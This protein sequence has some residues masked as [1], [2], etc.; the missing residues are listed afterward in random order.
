MDAKDTD[1]E[2]TDQRQK[3]SFEGSNSLS[4]QF[5]KKRKKLFINLIKLIQPEER[6][7]YDND[8]S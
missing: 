7:L 5:Q 1:I 6:T 8:R 2:A 4:K 3:G